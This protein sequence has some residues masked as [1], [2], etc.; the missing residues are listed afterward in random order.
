MKLK[1]GKL[2]QADHETKTNKKF[3]LAELKIYRQVKL[4]ETIAKN[5]ITLAKKHQN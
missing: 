2:Q 5:I 1:C 3:S 4:P